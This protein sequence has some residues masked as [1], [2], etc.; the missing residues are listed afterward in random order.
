MAKNTVLDELGLSAETFEAAKAE[1]STGGNTRDSGVYKF[2]ITEAAIFVTEKEAKMFKISFKDK[3]GEE[4]IDYQNTSYIAK[5]D[6][7]NGVKKGDRV[8]NK[9]G[10][11]ILKSLL[12]AAGIEPASL[13]LEDV[14]I[15][16]YAN[17][18]VDAKSLKELIGRAVICMVR[19]VED[20]SSDY[21]ESN[22]VEG[23]ADI[24]GNV[25]GSDENLTKWKE[26]IEKF[27]VLVKKA[28]KGTGT[29]T[30][31]SSDEAKNQAKSLLDD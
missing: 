25:N 12:A 24:E 30:T 19:K 23:Y 8:E 11:H 18:D 7:K 27:P 3:D 4:F 20:S 15:K 28:K 29:T 21:P 6:G 16:A 13:T 10:A 5:K 31:A 22:A 14:K 2:E 17:E 1:A 26:K 9:G